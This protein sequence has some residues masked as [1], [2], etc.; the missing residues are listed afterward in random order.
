MWEKDAVF[1]FRYAPFEV[2]LGYPVEISRPGA[3]EKG[4]VWK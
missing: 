4:Q 1:I 3:Q 2:P